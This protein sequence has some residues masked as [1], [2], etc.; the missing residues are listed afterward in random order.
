MSTLST[1][2][3]PAA[4]TVSRNPAA[5]GGSSVRSRVLVNGIAVPFTSW[6]VELKGFGAASQATIRLGLKDVFA[7][8]AGST[9]PGRDPKDTPVS[10]P[11]LLGDPRFIPTPLVVEAGAPS[12]PRAMQAGE[13]F[14]VFNGYVDTARYRG[15]EDEV[16]LVGRDR[17]RLFIETFTT[18]RWPN[19]TGSAIARKLATKH[20]L[21]P[22]ITA[23][24]TPAGSYYQLDAVTLTRGIRE[25]DLLLFLARQDAMNLYVKGLELHY[26]PFLPP[27]QRTVYSFVWRRGGGSN[28]LTYTLEHSPLA[29]H[30]F[31]VLVRSHHPKT[32]EIVTAQLEVLGETYLV[33]QQK[34]YR[35]GVYTGVQGT[36]VQ[37]ALSSRFQGKPVY[38]FQI[39]G[40][41]AQQAV[42]LARSIAFQIAVR[43]YALILEVTGNTQIDFLSGVQVSGIHP[44]LDR[45]Y[46]PVRILHRYSPREG[47]RTELHGLSHVPPVNPASL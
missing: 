36:T 22:V 40:L 46:F 9:M 45:V 19:L 39:E 26:E 2:D 21:T 17:T 31:I 18:E 38:E 43:E 13:L 4:A 35:A 5:I 44:R 28:V 15:R 8:I 47:L 34:T 16:E 41:K 30:D 14:Q 7:P 24:T 25:W 11:D 23:T 27:D 12:D 20:G 1:D 6:E 33:P 29:A 10:L 3:P 37:S 42:D 32:T